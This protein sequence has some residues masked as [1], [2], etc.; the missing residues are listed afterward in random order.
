MVKKQGFRAFFE[1]VAL[2]LSPF[3]R[4]FSRWTLAGSTMSSFWILY[5]LRVMEVVLTTR[6]IRCA[7][8]QSK[9]YH[10][11]TNTQFY[12][13]PYALPVAHPSVGALKGTKLSLRLIIDCMTHLHGPLLIYQPKVL[14]AWFFFSEKLISDSAVR[15]LTIC[16]LEN[17]INSGTYFST[18]SGIWTLAVWVTVHAQ[19]SLWPIH[20]GTSITRLGKT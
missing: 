8:L 20:Y 7:K 1:T 6:A 12:Y 18:Q 10:Q 4:P 2:S 14:L 5:E 15:L 3:W 19:H 9:C 17:T 11:Q 16:S 13:R